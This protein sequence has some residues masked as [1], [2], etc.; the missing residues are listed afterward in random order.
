LSTGVLVAASDGFFN[1]AKRTDI[2][3]TVMQT[4][5]VTLPRKLLELVRLKTGQLWDDAA[6]VVCRKKRSHK[7]RK[8]YV[9]DN[10]DGVIE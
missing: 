8:R 10:I 6:I 7:T 3:S 9:I 1:Y 5:F 2:A 4:D